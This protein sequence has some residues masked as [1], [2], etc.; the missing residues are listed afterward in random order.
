MMVHR[1]VRLNVDINPIN[2]LHQ[3]FKRLRTPISNLFNYTCR[4]I[5]AKFGIDIKNLAETFDLHP[6]FD[7]F[8]ESEFLMNRFEFELDIWLILFFFC[9]DG[10]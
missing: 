10:M 2:R 1:V 7:R 3:G 9:R 4:N 6:T 5:P 8:F